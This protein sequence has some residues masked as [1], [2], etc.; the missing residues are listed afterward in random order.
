MRETGNFNRFLTAS[1]DAV[2]FNDNG[3]FRNGMEGPVENRPKIML[4][5]FDGVSLTT[6]RWQQKRAVHPAS[7]EKFSRMIKLRMASEMA[8]VEAGVGEIRLCLC[9][10]HIP[11]SIVVRVN[12]DYIYQTTKNMCR[13]L[14]KPSPVNRL[15]DAQ[16]SV[17][18]YTLKLFCYIY[19]LRNIFVI[20]ALLICSLAYIFNG[21]NEAECMANKHMLYTIRKASVAR[22][23]SSNCF[24]TNERLMWTRMPISA[25]ILNTRV[26]LHM[27]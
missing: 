19:A 22:Q 14:P 7:S 15:G 16:S 13:Q 24:I 10:T 17:F 11:I 21:W 25:S 9:K 12:M 27:R 4:V 26:I 2:C 6:E 23:F 18:T 1:N 5:S 20:N 8:Q 3:F